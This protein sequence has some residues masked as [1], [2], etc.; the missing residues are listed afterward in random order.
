MNLKILVPNTTAGRIIGKGGQYIEHI[1]EESGAYV[2]ISQKSRETKL[3]ERCVTVAGD[4]LSNRKAM[5]MI[6]QKI[7]EDPYS[8]NF[9]T[10]SYADHPGPVANASPTGSPF[11]TY[12][13][14]DR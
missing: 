5:D 14:N 8:G 2:Q 9:P 1:K 11:A 6:L 4:F 7:L 12:S 3:P 10:I 13:F